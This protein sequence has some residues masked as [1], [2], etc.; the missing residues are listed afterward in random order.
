MANT[1]RL[2]KKNYPGRSTK[3]TGSDY[4][5]TSLRLTVDENKTLREAS[6]KVGISF[7][8]WAVQLLTAEAKK[9]LKGKKS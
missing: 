5:T 9:L 1:Q 8:W 4:M 7:N 2:A 6:A 3:E